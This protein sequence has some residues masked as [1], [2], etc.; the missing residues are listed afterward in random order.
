MIIEL[1]KI[2]GQFLKYPHGRN[3]LLVSFLICDSLPDASP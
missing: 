2:I 1:L 3:F